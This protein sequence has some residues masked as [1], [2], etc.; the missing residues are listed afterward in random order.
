M[1][2]TIPLRYA[3][4]LLRLAPMSRQQLEREL[5]SALF[6]TA[7]LLP[8]RPKVQESR[9]IRRIVF[10]QAVWQVVR[11]LCFF[12][13]RDAIDIWLAGSIN[14]VCLECPGLFRPCRACQASFPSCAPVSHSLLYGP[15]S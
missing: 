3:Q 14:E 15:V 7:C 1:A 6:P 9:F 2:D 12:T 4:S 11:Y 5:G 8:T 13:F 10:G